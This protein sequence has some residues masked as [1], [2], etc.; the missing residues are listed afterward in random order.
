MELPERAPVPAMG[1]RPTLPG[2][3]TEKQAAR[4]NISHDA[5][6]VLDRLSRLRSRLGTATFTLGEKTRLVVINRRMSL[7]EPP[8]RDQPQV[9]SL[10]FFD[11]PSALVDQVMER[12][13]DAGV[14]LFF[15]THGKRKKETRIRKSTCNFA[16]HT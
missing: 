4:R 2:H 1:R 5:P 16:T 3:A 7:G 10:R 15:L 9:A 13:W 14:D 8:L 11:Q 6:F 12:I